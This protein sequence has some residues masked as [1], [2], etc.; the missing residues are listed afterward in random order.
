MRK[1]ARY[2]FDAPVKSPAWVQQTWEAYCQTVERWLDGK[3]RR[4]EAGEEVLYSDGR[5]ASLKSQELRSEAGQSMLWE[6]EEPSN[7]GIFRTILGIAHD[8]NS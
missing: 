4:D 8:S 1:L 6:L 2:A 5:R 3:G 7:G